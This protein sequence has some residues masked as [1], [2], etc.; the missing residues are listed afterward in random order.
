MPELVY[1][2][3]GHIE[4][5]RHRDSKSFYFNGVVQS[6][7]PKITNKSKTLEDGNSDWDFEF[8]A[9]RAGDITINLNSFQPKLY[10]AIVASTLEDK[11]NLAIRKI[12]E[13]AI[14]VVSP[15]TVQVAKTPTGNIVIVNQDDSPFVS[16]GS[17]PAI[18]QY[19][20]SADTF[21]FSSADTGK[22]VVI[23]YDF[24]AALASQMQLEAQANNDVFKMTVAGQGVD[25]DNE[26]VTHCDAM[27]FDRVMP[28][29]DVSMPPRQK[30]PAGWNFN[31]KVM[32][33][34]PGYK[35]VDYRVER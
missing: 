25:K 32:K 34:R 14:P 16:V 19:S 23:A 21:T 22:A 29:G 35:V 4:L 27:I 20:V 26:A 9:G 28:I 3:A 31:M 10:A 24:T 7:V 1:K 30:E 13:Y 33:P 2:S 11:T 18:G 6:I 15:F 17:A 12:D 5:F 8:S